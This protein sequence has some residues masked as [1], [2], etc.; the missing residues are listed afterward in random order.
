M[1]QGELV[2]LLVMGLRQQGQVAHQAQEREQAWWQEVQGQVEGRA[3]L[4]PGPK[5]RVQPGLA[6]ERWDAFGSAMLAAELVLLAGVGY[7]LFIWWKGRSP[8]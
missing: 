8:A 5:V 2:Q 4:R 3:E 6:Q 7:G 1:Q